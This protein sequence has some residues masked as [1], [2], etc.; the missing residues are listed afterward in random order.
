MYENITY[1]MIL[2]RM[3]DK[4]AS[5][6][7]KREGSIIY[8]ALAPAAVE[9]QNM[10]I[11]FD[12]ILNETYADTA[13]RPYLIKRAAERGITPDQATKAILKGEFNKAVSIGDRFSLDTLNYIVIALIDNT[14]NSYELQCETVGT[15]GN[16][17]FGT[18]IPIEYI[19]G[20]TSAQLTELLIP[21]EDEEETEA[22]RSRYNNSLNSQAFGG[23]KADYKEEV[24]K[25]NGVGATKVY[26]VWNGGGTVKIVL[27]NSEFGVPSATLVAEVQEIM[28]PVANQGKG[29]GIAPIGH[30]VTI[31]GVTN[32]IINTSTTITYQTGWT[33]EDSKP[34]IEAAMDAYFLE[35]N[36]TWSANDNLIVRISQ[37]ETRLLNVAGVLD[38]ANTTLNGVAENFVVDPNK[39]VLRGVVIG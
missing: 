16:S 23:N 37:L 12:V 28:D 22:L 14:A 9:L 18:L 13:S 35:L 32:Q 2:G 29:L 10:Y 20:L 15:V 6:V 38:I 26:P 21:G 5:T 17:N 8:N 4:V 33:F 7:D 36:K 24:N 27:I 11:E 19:P 31:E 30:I 25:I 34:Y 39:I 1:E 3:L